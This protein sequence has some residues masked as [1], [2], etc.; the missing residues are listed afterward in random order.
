MTDKPSTRGDADL[1]VT[2][3]VISYNSE[4]RIGEA[5]TAHETALSHLASEII[6]VD[7]NSQDASVDEARAAI[8]NGRV[9]ANEVNAGYGTA[10]NQAIQEARGR[11]CLILNDDA[12][13]APGSIELLIEALD[14]SE[15]VALVGPRIVDEKGGPMPSARLTFPGPCEELERLVNMVRGRNR[16]EHYPAEDGPTEVAWL[17]AACV[18][19]RT[20]VLR[21]VGGFNTAFFLYSEDIDLARRLTD[22]EYKI[23]TVPD[24]VCVHTGSVSTGK[25]FGNR[26]SIE[27][28]T[29]ARDIYYRIWQPRPVRS[30]IHLR[31]AVG[32]SNQPQRL[33]H[34]LPRVIWDGRSLNHLRRQEPLE[35]TST[36]TE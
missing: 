31:R 1:D 24:A 2:A 17:V 9:I 15:Q 18:L 35:G 7:N 32:V 20:D 6:V 30:L 11:A 27:R 28:R 21:E 33:M 25:T 13:L 3:I 26:T 16:N 4:G 5:V 19:G 23:L 36:R 29:K 8:I 34:H 14:S 22:L 12:R 10:A